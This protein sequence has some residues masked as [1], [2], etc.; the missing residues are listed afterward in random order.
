VLVPGRHERPVATDELPL[1][2]GEP[3]L[4][5]SGE[6][7]RTVGVPRHDC[8]GQRAAL[9]EIVMADLGDGR[10]EPVLELR[11]RRLDVLALP[12][13]RPGGGE[14]QLDREDRDEARAQDSPADAAPAPVA[15]SSSDVRSTSRVS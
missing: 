9:P 8:R 3:C 7:L 1:L 12:L 11:L 14:V 15:T 6:L 5:P 4:R 13:Q 10:A 2:A